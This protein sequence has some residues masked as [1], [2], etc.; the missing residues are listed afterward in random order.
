MKDL[1]HNA[2]NYYHCG[3]SFIYFRPICEMYDN[4]IN[5][6]KIASTISHIKYDWRLVVDKHKMNIGESI[7]TID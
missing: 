6:F 5:A 2:L 1:K 7:I 4:N 3:I